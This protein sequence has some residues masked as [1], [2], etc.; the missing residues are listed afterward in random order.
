QHVHA[1]HP[2]IR[3]VWTQA[4][5]DGFLTNSR[6]KRSYLSDTITIL[7]VDVPLLTV[8]PLGFH[9]S[10]QAPVAAEL[11]NLE[12][13]LGPELLAQVDVVIT[14]LQQQPLTG[15]SWLRHNLLA[16]ITARFSKLGLDLQ[17]DDS[18]LDWLMTYQRTISNQ[19]DWERLL[20]EQVAPALIRYLPSVPGKEATSLRVAYHE[21]VVHVETL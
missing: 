17:W 14:Q 3:D 2:T 8:Q 11:R 7:T 16:D 6:G 20:D 1:C 9:A 4:L 18:L 10:A 21:S 19:R 12:S 13:I 15:R 5:S